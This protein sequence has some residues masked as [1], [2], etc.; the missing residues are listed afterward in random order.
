[1]SHKNKAIMYYIAGVICI[2]GAFC[3]LMDMLSGGDILVGTLFLLLIIPGIYLH[4]DKALSE[5][6]RH[7][8][9][10]IENKIKSK[11]ENLIS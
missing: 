4:H 5:Y 7:I 1:M 3:T 9:W 11:N 6:I 2:L 10:E 8:R